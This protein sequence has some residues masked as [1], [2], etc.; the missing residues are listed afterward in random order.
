[1]VL[2]PHGGRRG[3]DGDPTGVRGASWPGG[4]RLGHA[5][6]KVALSGGTA[7]EKFRGP[8]RA[9][10]GQGEP[11]PLGDPQD[12]AW[13]APSSGFWVQEAVRGAHL[14]RKPW[15]PWRR[16]R[17]SF[18]PRFPRLERRSEQCSLRRVGPGATH[19]PA[20]PA[21]ASVR[22]HR[23]GL[24]PP[25]PV[26]P[27]PPARGA[28][29]CLGAARVGSGGAHPALLLARHPE[30]PA[31]PELGGA[32]RSPCDPGGSFQTSPRPGR[33]RRSG[34]RAAPP[35]RRPV[36]AACPREESVSAGRRGAQ[37]RGPRL[38][39]SAGMCAALLV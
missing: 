12:K 29:P 18:K 9:G 1:M 17:R 20:R 5:G 19:V 4:W 22:P 34:D 32:R 31:L 2:R 11:P 26:A 23:C 38:G 3:A 10:P 30:V 6:F 15:A 24:N 36:R 27:F 25:L 33:W 8:L 16:G 39:A 37:D 13:C 14:Q 28:L 7:G 35:P 21:G